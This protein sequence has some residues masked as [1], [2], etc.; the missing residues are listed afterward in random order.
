LVARVLQEGVSTIGNRPGP[1]TR[2][3]IQGSVA[4]YLRLGLTWASA[5]ELLHILHPQAW[6]GT[7]SDAPVSQTWIYYSF[8]TLTTMGYGDIT[9][10]HPVA[11]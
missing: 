4:V 8:V 6:T 9:P 1:I 10:V 7:A 5:H 3:R 11:R 2:E